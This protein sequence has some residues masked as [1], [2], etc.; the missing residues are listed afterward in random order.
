[1]SEAQRKVVLG[2]TD[3]S[4]NIDTKYKSDNLKAACEK[5]G[6]DYDTVSN[7]VDS[8][9]ALVKTKI[10]LTYQRSKDTFGSEID[11]SKE[12]YIIP[13]SMYIYETMGGS[14][15]VFCL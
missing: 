5:Y 6:L 1:M 15:A 3:A 12:C 13:F 8:Y 7:T 2:E 11:S 9:N 10:D 14:C 4:T